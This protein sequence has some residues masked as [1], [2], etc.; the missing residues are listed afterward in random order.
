MITA[1][2]VG[3]V[4]GA[5]STIIVAAVLPMQP[6]RTKDRRTHHRT[7]TSIDAL[8]S[9]YRCGALTMVQASTRMR[10]FDVAVDIASRL[11]K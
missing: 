11:F 1:A 10:E 3:Y 2:I 4:F 6:Q 9:A 8:A 5:L 7:R